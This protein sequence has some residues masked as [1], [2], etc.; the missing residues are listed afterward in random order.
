MTDDFKLP[1][2]ERILGVVPDFVMVVDENGVI[3]YINRLE[4]GYRLEEVIGVE[5]HTMLFPESGEVFRKHLAHVLATGEEAHFDTSMSI[6]HCAEAWYRNRMFQL[7]GGG[8]LPAVVLVSR[9]ITELKNAQAS[10]EQLRKLLPVCAW[11]DRIRNDGGDWE[12]IETY[13]M[14]QTGTT[15][16]HGMCPTCAAGVVGGD[17]G[18]EGSAGPKEA[19][20]GAA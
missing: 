14:K 3:R 4:P 8:G 18:P 9:N 11:C 6:P 15:V 12:S 5:A 17:Q 16:T 20:G 7:E 10:A 2:L 19:D 13:L 1:T